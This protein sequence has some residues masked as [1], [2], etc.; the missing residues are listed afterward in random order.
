MIHLKK[1]I[2]QQVLSNMCLKGFKYLTGQYK[3][4]QGFIRDIRNSESIF[5]LFNRIQLSAHKRD[6]IS[7]VSRILSKLFKYFI[8]QLLLSVVMF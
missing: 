6:E 8:S 4:E 7:A 2:T 3:L 5:F 1:T